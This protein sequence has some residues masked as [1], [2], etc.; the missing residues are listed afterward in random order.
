MLPAIHAA[1]SR[2]RAAVCQNHLRQ[3]SLATAH[4][5]DVEKRIPAPPQPGKISGWAIAIL[6]FLE[7]NNLADF[8]NQGEPIGSAPQVLLRQ[9]AIMRCPDQEFRDEKAGAGMHPSHFVLHPLD[10]RKRYWISDCP[11]DLDTAWANSPEEKFLPKERR[12]PHYRGFH[13]CYGFEHGTNWE[14]GK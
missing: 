7:Q 4:F 3:L 11:I 6:P 2:A 10:D 8:A 9:P 13:F 1:R 12:G 14:E 5:F